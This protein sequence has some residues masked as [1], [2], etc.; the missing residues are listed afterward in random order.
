MDIQDAIEK[1]D[2]IV[3]TIDENI[4]DIGDNGVEFYEDVRINVVDMQE[5]LVAMESRGWPHAT[6]NQVRALNNWESGIDAWI[7]G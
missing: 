4:S 3:A 7:K 1:C 6:D 2:D 5:S